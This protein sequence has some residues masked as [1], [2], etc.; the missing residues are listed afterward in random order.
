MSALAGLALGLVVV[1]GTGGATGA[2]AEPH[3]PWTAEQ[4]TAVLRRLEA[5]E[6][7]AGSREARL[8]GDSLGWFFGW[9]EYQLLAGNPVYGY[10]H[11]GRFRWAGTHVAF[12]GI[13]PVGHSAHRITERAWMAAFRYIAEKNGLVVDPKATIRVRGACL[14]AVFDPGLDE[15]NRGVILELRI[16][17]PTGPFLYRFGFGKPTVEDAIGASLDW[18]VRFARLANQAATP[19]GR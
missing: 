18:A 5:R 12:D 1:A 2:A 19:A 3:L 14:A 11:E 9:P 15:P 4:T 10:W 13:K 6:P 8:H 7:F 16:E 17:S